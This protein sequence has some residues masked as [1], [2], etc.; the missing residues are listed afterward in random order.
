MML[1]EISIIIP[2]FNCEKFILKTL[3][4]IQ[5]QTYNNWECIIVDDHST[6]NSY[7]LVKSFIQNDNRFRLFKRPKHLI[8]GSSSCRNYGFHEA[9]AEFIWW[10]DADDIMMDDAIENILNTYKLSPH[11]KVVCGDIIITS[12]E[13][14]ELY[15]YEL[16]NRHNIYENFCL[17]KFRIITGSNIYRRAYLENF[18][19]LFD[20]DIK[21]LEDQ[22]FHSRILKP[23]NDYEIGLVQS[24]L[25]YYIKHDNAKSVTKDNFF[26]GNRW[27]DYF[28]IFKKRLELNLDSK[29][30]RTYFYRELIFCIANNISTD[31][32]LAK[33]I[34]TYI[35]ELN[36]KFHKNKLIWKLLKKLGNQKLSIW[37]TSKITL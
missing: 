18:K 11:Y 8:K 17:W 37:L 13:L 35:I 32:P 21:I 12:P 19:L 26:D 16:K 25:Y 5:A 28:I 1:P 2:L 23:L 27:L 15:R 33:Y 31:T 22:E 14:E 36:N 10:F 9:N 4:S 29:I 3:K 30:I 7:E 6:D 24:F 34:D 20:G